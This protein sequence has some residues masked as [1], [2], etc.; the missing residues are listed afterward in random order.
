M[1]LRPPIST[2]TDTLFP[3][4]TLFRTPRSQ[5]PEVALEGPAAV[6]VRRGGG[7]IPVPHRRSVGVRIDHVLRAAAEERGDPAGR[8]LRRGRLLLDRRLLQRGQ[9]HRR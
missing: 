5:R 1:T 6:A 3:Y 8:V 7:R 4:T 9:P 2:R